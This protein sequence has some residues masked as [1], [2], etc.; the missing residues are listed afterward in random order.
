MK[1]SKEQYKRTYKALILDVDGTIILNKKDS[2]P[3]QKT[4]KAIGE[5]SKHLYVC[6]ATSRPYKD[7]FEIINHLS[8]SGYSVINGGSQIIDGKSKK[9]VWEQPMLQKDVKVL[10][11]MFQ[12]TLNIPFWLNDGVNDL[13]SPLR[14]LPKRIY[15]IYIGT[16]LS[17]D[18]ADALIDTISHIPTIAAHKV[19][20]WYKGYF[21]IIITH[22]LATKQ[23]GIFEVAKL[24][25]INTHD[26]IGVGDGYNDFPLL[27]AC[28]LKVAMGNA[29]PELKEIADYIAP[30]VEEDGIADVVKKFIFDI[31]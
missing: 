26:I 22:A 17:N 25:D 20:S 18:A 5:A 9:I 2:M 6:L 4:T 30:S 16:D 28:G 3:S 23:H 8:L 11:D 19:P 24:L 1:S 13:G 7:A 15:Q 29:V 12:H 31:S 27:M 10:L 21:C 14:F